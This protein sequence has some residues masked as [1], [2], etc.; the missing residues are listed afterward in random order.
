[1]C[2]P[3]RPAPQGESQIADDGSPSL[4][5]FH[6]A[7]SRGSRLPRG[8]AS[9]A[10]S[11]ASRDWRVSVPYS[12]HERTSKYTSP[13]AGYACPRSISRA[14]S[15]CICGTDAVA[16]GSYVGGRMPIAEYAAVNS[17]SMRYARAHH[18]SSGVP[19]S[20]TLSSMSV[21]LRT[22]VTWPNRWA[23]QR[24]SRSNARAPRR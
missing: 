19:F 8:S 14:M 16:R 3:G 10:G 1:M 15:S 13:A 7:K 5:P 6:S 23:S 4:A 9:A 12:A 21:T 2:Q 24:R 11:M 22:S 17:C 20:S 18:G